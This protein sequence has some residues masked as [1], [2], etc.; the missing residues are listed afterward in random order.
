VSYRSARYRPVSSRRQAL[1]RAVAAGLLAGCFAGCYGQAQA[2]VE[3]NDTTFR[4][5]VSLIN[6]LVTVKDAQGAPIG[7]LNKEDFT[8]L[9]GGVTRPVTVFER[10]TDRPL[11]VTLMIDASLSTAVELE[12]ERISAR[13][14]V[15]NLL[16]QGSHPRDRVAVLKFSAYVDLLAEFTRSVPAITRALRAVRSESGTSMYDAILLAS[17]ELAGREGRRVMIIITDGGDTTSTVSFERA[18]RATHA[19]DGVIYGMIVMPI[20][21]DAGRNTGGENALKALAS[22]TGGATF[23]QLGT[24]TLDEAFEQI[25]RNLRTQYLLGYYPPELPDTNETFRSIEVQVNRPDVTVLARKGYFLPE[26][27]RVPVITH[28]QISIRPKL[29]EQP[30]AKPADSNAAEKKKP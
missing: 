15:E 10:R 17:E 13:R 23:V 18:L 2:E 6:V 14:F 12:Q 7:G 19:I 29:P 16:R 28:G 30:A 9:D 25:L 27:R 8:I 20:K 1:T 26:P 5:D 24:D 22:N 21:S 3:A 11:S 4:I